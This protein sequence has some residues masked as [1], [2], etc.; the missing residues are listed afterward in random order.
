[1]IRTLVSVHDVMPHT[2]DAVHEQLR[3]LAAHG[4]GRATL[5]VVPGLDWTREGLDRLRAWE[6][7]GHELAGHGWAHRVE[8]VRG[9]RHR[10][11]A[12]LVSR[13]AAEHMA[14]DR[15]GI[16]S[17]LLRNRE[18]FGANGLRAPAL[19][20]PPAWALGDAPLE[21]YAA[22]GFRLVEGL[23]GVHDLG[24]GRLLRIPAIG[25]EAVNAWRASVLRASNAGNRWLAR[26]QGWLRLAL[27]PGDLSLPLA[28]EALRDITLLGDTYLY[29]DLLPD[30]DVPGYPPWRAA[31]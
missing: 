16:E 24:T 3:L 4:V 22:A 7:D 25:Y 10:V 13:N 6:A 2:L 1:M 9:V 28:G 27:H 29:R 30:S 5:L 15:S 8:R 20:V 11:Y 12:A 14:L 17:L 21:A 19:Y 31:A 26:R 18:W 23:Q